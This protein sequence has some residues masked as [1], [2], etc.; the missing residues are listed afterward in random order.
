[1]K[2]PLTLLLFSGVCAAY[3]ATVQGGLFDEETQNPLARTHV[4]LAP[5]PGTAVAPA[6]QLSNDNGQFLFANVHPGWYLIRA[7]RIGYATAEYGQYRPG[8]PGTPFEVTDSA[9]GSAAVELRQIVMR[10]QAAITGSVVDDNA[11]GIPGW[12]I[13]VY[14]A[15]K[16]VRRIAQGLTDD[17]GNFRVGELE[18]GTYIVRSGAGGLEGGS[19][20]VPSYYKYGTAVEEAE[21]VHVRLG[22]TQGF[23]VIHTVEGRLF[24]LTGEVTAPDKK[25][26]RV[27]LI[28]DTGR[29]M[30]GNSAGPFTATGVPPGMAE[31]LVEGTG[32]AGYQTV[33][34]DR[35]M[36]AR[37]DC[38]P[39]AAPLISGALS[40]PVMARRL[41]LDGPG[42]ESAVSA[43]QSFGPGHWEFTV[44]PGA[45]HYLAGIQNEGD[46]APPLPVDGWFGLDV[47]NAPHLQVTLSAK[48][49]SLSG[50]ASS[51]GK[52]V[53]GAPV[54]LELVNPD[55]PELAT[56]SWLVRADP[57][58][59]FVFEGLAPGVYRLMSSFYFDYEDPIARDKAVTVTLREGD[60]ITQ[61]LE[62]ILQ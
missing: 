45:S 42:A 28:T 7:S 12:A 6:F 39:F 56:Q 17:R 23:V 25:P 58:G 4:T 30:I 31:L 37:V 55:A 9:V 2:L 22:E 13:S 44:R 41:D 27:T 5:L 48:P 26:V 8:L 19:T 14:T 59:N 52:T 10:R 49:A 15:R 16:P 57:Q 11:I 51:L 62:M 46:S 29:R 18:P 61:P 40:Y 1:V 47:G 33:M 53:I 54:F 36:F 34:V 35:N 24:E 43:G 32:C 3:G 38:L 20:L 60:A 50:V 21:T